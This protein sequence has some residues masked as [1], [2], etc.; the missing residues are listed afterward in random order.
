MA[1]TKIGSAA[2]TVL[3]REDFFTIGWGD[4]NLLDM[5]YDESGLTWRYARDRQPARRLGKPGG[6][7][8]PLDRYARVLNALGRDRRFQKFLFRCADN[9][10]RERLMRAFRCRELVVCI[11]CGWVGRRAPQRIRA[12]PKKCINCG[13][14]GTVVQNDLAGM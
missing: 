1:I 11:N 14:N 5:V 9:G 12:W 3:E 4:L 6:E 10:G 2:I 7:L 8:H 13:R